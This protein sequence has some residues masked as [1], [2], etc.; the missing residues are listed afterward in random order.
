MLQVTQEEMV[1]FQ[2]PKHCLTKII[3]I[4]ESGVLNCKEQTGYLHFD[5]NGD[6]RLVEFM[7]KKRFKV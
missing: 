2:L 6:I 4:I 7:N 1:Q 3:Q 5:S